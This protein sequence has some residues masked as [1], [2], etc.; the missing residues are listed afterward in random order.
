LG[1][2]D[3]SFGFGFYALRLDLFAVP[4]KADSG[5]VADPD[6]QLLRGVEGRCGGCNQCFLRYK[7]SVGGDGY[8]RIFG[9][10]DD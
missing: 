2:E 8:P 6:Y 7:L 5:G 4:D 9:G 1:V 10:A 3:E